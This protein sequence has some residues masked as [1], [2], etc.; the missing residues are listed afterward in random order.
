MPVSRQVLAWV[1]RA[2]L[3]F[4]ELKWRM[5][6][7]YWHHQEIPNNINLRHEGRFKAG[8]LGTISAA[9][10]AAVCLVSGRASDRVGRRASAPRPPSP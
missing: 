4:L 9:C 5:F 7:L 8:L 3:Q 6:L 10:Y 1:R 2:P